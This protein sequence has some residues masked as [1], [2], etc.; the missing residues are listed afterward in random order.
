MHL[1]P[2]LLS[3]HG[4]VSWT[5]HLVTQGS[6]G[7]CIAR[8]CVS[9]IQATHLTSPYSQ[10]HVV[11]SQTSFMGGLRLGYLAEVDQS[12]FCFPWSW[13]LLFH[14]SLNPHPTSGT[15]NSSLHLPAPFFTEKHPSTGLISLIV[16]ISLLLVP[17]MHAKNIQGRGVSISSLPLLYLAL[18]LAQRNCKVK[19]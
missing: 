7:G 11:G 19:I 15:S 16:V 14:L 4:H 5:A 3:H 9:R 6:L 2:V 12:L 8:L 13:G 10:G 18:A 1:P 17:L